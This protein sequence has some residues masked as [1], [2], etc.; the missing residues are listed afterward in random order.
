MTIVYL[1]DRYIRVIDGEFARG[2]VK[3]KGL[4]YTIDTQGCIINGNIMDAEGL[5]ELIREL[6]ESK[7]LPKKDV[8]LV[9]NSTQITTKVVQA[10]LMKK[11]QLMEFVEREFAD[12]ERIED[13]VC[14]Y[15]VMPESTD[16]K[17][18]TQD[19]FAAVAS[20]E[21]LKSYIALFEGIGV[22][23]S[24]IE[25]VRG[26]ILRFVE[27]MEVLKKRTCIVQIVDGSMLIN[28]ILY[29]GRFM[30]TGRARLFGDEG[31]PECAVEVARSVS[32]VLQFAKSQDIPEKITEVFIAGLQEEI[33]DI[34][35]DSVQ[36]I[37]EALVAERISPADTIRT[38]QPEQAEQLSEYCA[39]LGA[40]WPVDAS[41]GFY[42]QM[43]KDPEKEA[44]RAQL[45]KTAAPI[46]ALTAVMGVAAGVLGFQ[47]FALKREIA[48]VQAFNKSES[49][50]AACEE[51]D[52]VSNEIRIYGTLSGSAQSLEKMVK[53]YPMMDSTVVRSVASCADGLVH[54][55]ISSYSAGNGILE[56]DTNAANVDLIHRFVARLE[57]EEL[58]EEI[59]YTGYQQ[60]SDGTWSVTVRCTMT[61]REVEEDAAVTETD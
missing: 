42:A 60:I 23:L 38:E 2:A 17:K 16:K 1:F 29:K 30:Y 21:A 22:K 51:Y 14:S 3:V 57:D 15:Y 26:S 33:M 43:T 50:I 24:R 55:E 12:V 36:R 47:Y 44:K 19:L 13:P 34:Y 32:N 53:M 52:A 56:L 18:K 46:A 49:V 11:K 27:G 54:T 5:A 58:F 59:D 31:T 41:T 28:I 6:W 37:D 45:I 39:A 20:R 9:Y 61:G 7:N 35:V 4:Y 40:L 8:C 48:E 25:G 10:P